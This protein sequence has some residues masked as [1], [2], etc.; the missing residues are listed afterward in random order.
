MEY[1]SKNEFILKFFR[2]KKVNSLSMETLKIVN[3][4]HTRK[5]ASFVRVI[6]ILI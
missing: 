5:T 4:N 6:F 2:F 3:Y 1:D